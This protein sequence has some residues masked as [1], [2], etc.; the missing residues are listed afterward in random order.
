MYCY[1]CEVNCYPYITHRKGLQA[2]TVL[3]LVGRLRCNSSNLLTRPPHSRSA[4][5]TQQA[6]HTDGWAHQ[7]S[8]CTQC[9]SKPTVALVQMW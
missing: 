6:R 1:P 4:C 9:T 7:A 5:N 2:V 3:P 8:Q